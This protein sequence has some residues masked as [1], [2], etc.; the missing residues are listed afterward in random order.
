MNNIN[1]RIFAVDF[2]DI[3]GYKQVFG[4]NGKD[5]ILYFVVDKHNIVSYGTHNA[6]SFINTNP[7]TGELIDIDIDNTQLR[8]LIEASVK[9]TSLSEASPY[10]MNAKIAELTNK[11][12][13]DVRYENSRV[14][15]RMEPFLFFK[16]MNMYKNEAKYFISYFKNR[17]FSYVDKELFKDLYSYHLHYEGTQI[18]NFIK[19][20]NKT[21]KENFFSLKKSTTFCRCF[22]LTRRK[23]F[24]IP[25]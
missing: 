24:L 21:V 18:Y 16:Y 22:L 23:L 1:S 17:L 6:L 15:N 25:V 3:A 5:K 12:F 14:L 8:S 9:K 13:T 10:S 7:E 20:A 11:L 2:E 4:L 19:K